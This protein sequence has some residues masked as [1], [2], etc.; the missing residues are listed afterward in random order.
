MSDS[1]SPR[2]WMTDRFGARIAP[3][4]LE[5]ARGMPFGTPRRPDTTRTAPTTT[6]VA[7]SII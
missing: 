6:G 2:P 1:T 7:E 4:S 5:H 3:G